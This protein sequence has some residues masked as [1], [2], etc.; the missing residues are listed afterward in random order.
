METPF[1]R[2]HGARALA[3]GSSTTEVIV[4]LNEYSGAR[5]DSLVGALELIRSLSSRHAL[6]GRLQTLT[7]KATRE[8][9]THDLNF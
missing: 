9:N 1:L 2:L 7:R 4:C 6:V 5:R 3:T 8:R